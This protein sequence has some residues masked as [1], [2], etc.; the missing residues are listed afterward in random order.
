MS[1]RGECGFMKLI[2]YNKGW[3]SLECLF[4]SQISYRHRYC[5]YLQYSCPQHVLPPTNQHFRPRHGRARQLFLA[6]VSARSSVI[7]ACVHMRVTLLFCSA[8]TCNSPPGSTCMHACRHTYI[9]TYM[10]IGA[11]DFPSTY[12]DTMQALDKCIYG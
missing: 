3:R 8:N 12:T 4:T 6:P 2:K 10:Y 1:V 5:T 9:Y 7:R 11:R